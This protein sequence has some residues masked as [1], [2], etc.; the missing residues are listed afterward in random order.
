MGSKKFDFKQWATL[1]LWVAVCVSFSSGSLTSNLFAA[2]TGEYKYLVPLKLPNQVYP[3]S[4]F[5]DELIICGLHDETQVEFDRENDGITDW[6]FHLD[7]GDI[8]NFGIYSGGII[9]PMD[10]PE[11][12]ALTSDK[13]ILIRYHHANNDYGLY[14]DIISSYVLL[15]TSMWGKEFYVPLMGLGMKVIACN[16]GTVV[17]VDVNHDGS[18]DITR[19]LNAG[20]VTL[21][22]GIPAG[23]HITAN[24][25]VFPVVYHYNSS[26]KDDFWTYEVLP[27][28]LQGKEYYAAEPGYSYTRM[29]IV[30]TENSSEV[31]VDTDANGSFDLVLNGN[32]G[33]V[34]DVYGF[35]AGAHVSCE[36]P[37]SVVLKNDRWVRDPWI[38]VYRHFSWAYSLFPID[39]GKIDLFKEYFLGT[40]PFSP[41]RVRVTSLIDGN[42]ISVDVNDDGVVDLSNMLSKQQSWEFNAPEKT[43][44]SSTQPCLMMSFNNAS[45]YDPETTDGH[46]HYPLLQDFYVLN[47]APVAICKDIEVFVDSACQAFIAP[48]DIDSGSYDPDDDPLLI[49]IDNAGPFSPGE[50]AVQ[51]TVEDGRGESDSCLSVVTVID[52]LPPVPDM[53]VLPEVAGQCSAQITSI[54]TAVDNCAGLVEGTT[55]DPLLYTEQG[56]YVV[57][58]TYNDGNGNTASQTQTVTVDDTTAPVIQSLSASPNELWPPNHK[59]VPVTVNIEVSDNCGNSVTSRITDVSGNE[60]VNGL[61]DGD[62]SPDW[63]ITGDLTLNLRAERS[64]TGN[65]RVYLIT[66][67]CSDE[68]GNSTTGTVTVT[69]PKSKKN[70]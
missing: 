57:T 17:D 61:G 54:P 48:E 37:L 41:N 52:A 67:E 36:S 34:L 32:R 50:Y 30:C 35:S 29:I 64:G 62:T 6:T 8:F 42:T 23:S 15:P 49:S 9:G 58:W 26:N 1:L 10:F 20:Q 4:D 5:A 12:A 11:G 43:Y 21:I 55:G 69:V 28:E 53:E 38:G 13:P 31:K 16:D 59:M 7:R 18:A 3:A 22:T 24:Q 63:E 56:T 2:G 47:R 68:Y 44:I 27:M 66:V 40:V 60:P 14:D 25:P 33:Q 46:L 70:T 65:G 39:Y 19:T 45:A 51:L